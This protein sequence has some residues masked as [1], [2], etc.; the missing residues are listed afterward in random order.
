MR[1]VLIAFALVLAVCT[2]LGMAQAGQGHAP[3]QHASV[4]RPCQLVHWRALG[5]RARSAV[6]GACR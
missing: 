2:Q 3:A 4:K 6:A 5:V 1:A